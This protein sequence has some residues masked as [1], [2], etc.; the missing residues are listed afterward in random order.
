M[1]FVSAQ[2]LL[3][4]ITIAIAAASRFLLNIVIVSFSFL[5]KYPSYVLLS[6]SPTDV[7]FPSEQILFISP[8][9][10]SRTITFKPVKF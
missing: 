8:S 10:A 1:S 4:S 3:L 2:V 9:I 7:H 5:I 6:V